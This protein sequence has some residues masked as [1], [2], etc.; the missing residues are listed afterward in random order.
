[1]IR[2]STVALLGGLLL[3]HTDAQ[4]PIQVGFCTSVK[5]M[6]AA[7][8]A[9]FDYVEVGTTEIAA[10]SDADFERTLQDA[11]QIGLPVPVANLFLP[12]TLKV[13]GPAVDSD[14]QLLYVRKA[15]S[16]LSRLGTRIVV[17]GSGGARRVPEGFPKEDAFR[18]LV[19]FGTR[20]APEAR[21]HGITVAIEP[22]R[23]EETNII[24]SAA[25]GLALV[26]AVNDPSFQLMIDFFH[27]ASERENPAIVRRANDHIRHLHMANPNGRVFPVAWDEYDYGPFFGALRESGYN[28]RISIEASS[29]DV[30]A[31]APRAIAL[32]RRAFER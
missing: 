25:E 8:A 24:N 18:Q 5:N 22:L 13:T 10:L 31:D 2:A 19:A 32:L 1:L 16:R 11:L 12:A 29:K 17:F 26:E 21:S 27:L 15:F 30:A 6:S 20:I 4:H 7:K 9:G 14:Q 28:Q 23:R 3:L